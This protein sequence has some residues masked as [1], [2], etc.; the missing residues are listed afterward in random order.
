M[1]KMFLLFS[2]TL[3]QEQIKDAK[4]S[5][6][7]EEFVKLPQNLQELWSNIP[8]DIKDLNSYLEP[9]KEWLKEHLKSEDYAL[10]Q[11]DFGATCKMAKFVKEHSAKAVYATTQRNAKEKM[12]D[13]KIVKTSIFKHIMFREF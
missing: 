9:I 8:P 6:E 5:L 12:V 4:K 3:T 7:I 10:I 1:P 11:G 13:G 2:H